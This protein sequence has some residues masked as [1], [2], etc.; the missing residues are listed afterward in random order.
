MTKITNIDEQIKTDMITSLELQDAIKVFTKVQERVKLIASIIAELENEEE[1]SKGASYGLKNFYIS[2]RVGPYSKEDVFREYLEVTANLYYF[3][4]Y[5]EDVD[6]VWDANGNGRIE[7]TKTV[8]FPRA[9]LYTDDWL[10]G[11][12][13]RQKIISDRWLDHKIEQAKKAVDESKKSVKSR[14]KFLTDLKAKRT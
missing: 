12:K 9:Y 6:N 1:R 10:D 3:N 8:N 5:D 2:P 11:A 4:D 13:A 7:R 14:E